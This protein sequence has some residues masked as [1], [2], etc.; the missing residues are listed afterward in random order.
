[1]VVDRRAARLTLRN[2]LVTAKEL[3]PDGRIITLFGCGGDRDRTKRPLM[4]EAAGHASDIVVLTSDNPRS[5]DPLLI[6]NDVIVGV[7]RTKAKLLV[8]LDRQKAIRV[9]LDEARVR[10]RSCS[11]RARG[12]KRTRYC[13]TARLILTTAK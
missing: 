10:R 13:A 7:Q 11:S 8:E 5:E 3:N 4:G 6:I 12:M 1:M 2:L 9:A